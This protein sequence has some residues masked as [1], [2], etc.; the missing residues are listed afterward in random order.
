MDPAAAFW[1][2]RRVLVTGC[3]GFLGTWAV[4][5]LLAAGASVTGLVRG[6]ES[7]SEF[8]RDRLFTRI[9]VIRGRVEDVFRLRYAL[10]VH[11]IDAVFHLA[12]PP[13]DADNRDA[14]ATSWLETVRAAARVAAPNGVV[15]APVRPD[16][17]ADPVRIAGRWPLTVLAPIPSRTAGPDAARLLMAAAESA[18][19]D[20]PTATARRSAA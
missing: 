2:Y 20:Q 14:V 18:A 17:A 6:R 1:P 9:R 15:V 4:R 8:F 10:A 7:D 13:A 3:T 19:T 11:E 16:R 5:E 12:G